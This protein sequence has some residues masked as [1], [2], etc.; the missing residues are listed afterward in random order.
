MTEIIYKEESFKIIRLCMEVHNNF[1]KE[2][3]EIVYRD[4]FEYQLNKIKFLMK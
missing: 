4:V 2:F 3:L 1:G